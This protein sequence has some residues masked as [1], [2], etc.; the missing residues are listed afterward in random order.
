VAGTS[1]NAVLV[2]LT[3]QTNNN[4]NP[5]IVG[6]DK[7]LENLDK[8]NLSAKEKLDLFGRSGLAAAN[9]LI[10]GRDALKDM[11]NAVTDTNT[12][13]EQMETKGGTLSGSFAKLKSSWDAFMITMGE[14]API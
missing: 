10:M 8:A 2:R 14:S 13:Y 1:L 5:A 11:T 7:A 4:F 6:L 12:A 3:T 9:T